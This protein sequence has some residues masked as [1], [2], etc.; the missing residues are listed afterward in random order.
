MRLEKDKFQLDTVADPG[1]EER[2]T[3]GACPQDFFGK[4]ETIQGTF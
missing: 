4:F 1:S 3:P 2:G